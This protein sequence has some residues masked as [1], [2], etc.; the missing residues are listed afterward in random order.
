LAILVAEW[1][2]NAGGGGRKGK[3]EKGS[4]RTYSSV[5]KSEDTY[6]PGFTHII[7]VFFFF[8]KSPLKVSIWPESRFKAISVFY[9]VRGNGIGGHVFFGLEIRGF[10][11]P[12]FG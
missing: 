8:G 12:C 3:N 5:G 11:F 10:I 6:F 1:G 2:N 9:T 4:E 7:Y